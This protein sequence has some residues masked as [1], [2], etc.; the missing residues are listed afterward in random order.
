MSVSRRGFLI[1]TGAAAVT[2]GLGARGAGAQAPPAPI[3]G[4]E[5]LI[6]RSPRPINLEAR[7]TDLTSYHTPEEVFFVRNNYDAPAVDPA[8]WTLRVEGEVEQPLVLRLEDLR[9]MPAFTQD[10]TL[11]CA[12]NGRSFH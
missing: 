4:K 12:G 3:P 11:E 6:V 8:Q 1:A 5:R 2:A 9:K 10:V 7:L